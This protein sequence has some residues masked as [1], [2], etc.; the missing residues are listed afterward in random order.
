MERTGAPGAKLSPTRRLVVLAFSF[1]AAL[2]LVNGAVDYYVTS[3]VIADARKTDNDAIAS[4][5]LLRRIARD[6]DRQRILVA[7]YLL[8]VS[9]QSLGDVERRVQDAQQDLEQAARAYT[10][11]LDLPEEL[12][13]WR[14]TRAGTAQLRVMSA[15]ALDLSARHR[16]AAARASWLESRPQRDTLDRALDNLITINQTEGLDATAKIESSLRYTS[17]ITELIR[18]AVLVIVGVL[19]VW[20]V[21]R[22]ARY[23]GQLAA[24]LERVEAANRDLDAFAGR[25]AH[26][27]NNVLGPIALSADLLRHSA[28]NP[29]RVRRIA[30]R[31]ERAS[32]RATDL[33]EALLAFARAPRQV[34]PGESASVGSAI[35]GVLEQ[36]RPAAQRNHATIE[37]EDGPDVAVR[38]EPTL[39]HAVLVNLVGNAIKY[40]DGQDVRHVRISSRREDGLCHIEVTDTGP[41]IPRAAQARLFEPFYRVERERGPKVPGTGLGLATVKRIVDARGGRVAVESEEGHGARF[42]VWLPVAGEQGA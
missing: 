7:D 25:V 40:L 11:L 35:A 15:R 14:I 27:L 26:D 1:I 21:R 16:E 38:C 2:I 5:H 32:Q 37:V 24:S 30:A 3:V 41:G 19:G 22:I 36:V 4:V 8:D 42:S 39:L 20:L 34:Q 31:A 18:L 12:T 29:D 23:E 33:V 17:M 28:D 6:A 13:A 10:P 9:A